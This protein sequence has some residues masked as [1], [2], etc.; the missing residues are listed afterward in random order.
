M[1]SD[2]NNFIKLC[3]NFNTSNK[4]KKLKVAKKIIIE[5]RAHYLYI[6]DLGH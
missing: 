2:I 5:N 3:P 4:I 1:I 6:V